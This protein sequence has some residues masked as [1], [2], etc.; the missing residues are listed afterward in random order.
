MTTTPDQIAERAK[1][2]ALVMLELLRALAQDADDYA[3][4]LGNEAAY[5]QNATMQREAADVALRSKKAFA[6]IAQIE[7]A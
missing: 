2:S 1:A 5:R 4:E 6:L 7:G 3:D